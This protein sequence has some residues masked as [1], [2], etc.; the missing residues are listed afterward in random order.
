M[1][2]NIKCHQD[3]NPAPGR[4][5]TGC[6]GRD[7]ARQSGLE[8]PPSL[9]ELAHQAEIA[10][11]NQPGPLSSYVTVGQKVKFDNFIFNQM[12]CVWIVRQALPWSRMNNTWLQA[13]VQ[14]LRPD[15]HIYGRRWVAEEAKRLNL[16]MKKIVFD[17]LKVSPVLK[18]KNKIW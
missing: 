5:K 17:E 7:E 18:Y 2:N 14:F 3:G 8:V 12:L 4:S 6:P 1:T 13:A 10:K 11:N 16:S 9:A 15:A